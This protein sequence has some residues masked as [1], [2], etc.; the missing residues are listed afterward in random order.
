MF[1]SWYRLL[2]GFWTIASLIWFA[3]IFSTVRR[4]MLQYYDDLE[5]PAVVSDD[6]V[7]FV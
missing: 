5:P 4:S 1:K 7:L 6:D 3:G 2:V